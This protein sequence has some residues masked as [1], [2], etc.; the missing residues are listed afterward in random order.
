MKWQALPSNTKALWSAG[1][2][3][4]SLLFLQL[5]FSTHL[6]ID[7]KMDLLRG[8]VDLKLLGKDPGEGMFLNAL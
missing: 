3:L 6:L 1:M 4:I 7:E 2:R 5:R 8:F